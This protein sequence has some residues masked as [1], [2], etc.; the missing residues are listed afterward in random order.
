M[1][2]LGIP[3]NSAHTFQVMCNLDSNGNGVIEFPEFLT[4]MAGSTK[5]S[6]V[7]IANYKE[8]FTLF[9]TN[10]DGK[11]VWP[12]Y[13]YRHWQWCRQGRLSFDVGIMRP[14]SCAAFSFV[15]VPT[16]Y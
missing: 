12:L 9:D 15:Y 1:T 6:E 3:S 5:D 11:S 10:Q 8:A 4:M 16:I 7:K 14:D 13:F 2:S